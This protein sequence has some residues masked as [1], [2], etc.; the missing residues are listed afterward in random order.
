MATVTAAGGHLKYGSLA[1]VAAGIALA[2]MGLVA[3]RRPLR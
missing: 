2:G 3:T 1:K